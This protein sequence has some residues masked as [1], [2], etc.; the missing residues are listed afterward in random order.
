MRLNAIDPI[1]QIIQVNAKHSEGT[2]TR[3]IEVHNIHQALQ[4]A[5]ETCS[6]V[7]NEFDTSFC[8][9]SARYSLNDPYEDKS[10]E[11]EMLTDITIE[12]Y[13]NNVP[14]AAE[15]SFTKGAPFVG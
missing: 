5:R 1:S 14:R 10:V 7:A 6:M 4:A 2:I 13:I 8:N 3:R 11:D 15:K 9:V 12:C